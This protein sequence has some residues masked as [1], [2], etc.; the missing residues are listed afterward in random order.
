LPCLNDWIY[1]HVVTS[2]HFCLA[3]FSLH[4]LWS[5]KWWNIHVFIPLTIWLPEVQC[6]AVSLLTK[7]FW[8][9]HTCIVQV[10]KGS[11]NFTIDRVPLKSNSALRDWFSICDSADL[12]I[13]TFV[14]TILPSFWQGYACCSAFHATCIYMHL[15]TKCF[16][17]VTYLS[18]L[19]PPSSLLT[20]TSHWLPLIGLHFLPATLPSLLPHSTNTVLWPPGAQVWAHK[21][22]E[23]LFR[24]FP[25]AAVQCML[26]T[27]TCTH[28][29][30]C[31]FWT[32]STTLW[33]IKS[34][35]CNPVHCH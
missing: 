32:S 25:P 9:C 13:S 19:L 18:F 15:Q 28:H 12:Y 10:Q 33:H 7:L 29:L 1:V 35:C 4:Y 6:C 8:W 27:Y 3:V 11:L 20:D 16:W 24:Q 31:T 2:P 14:R 34:T 17:L 23:L 26:H 22:G 21:W 5:W 30:L